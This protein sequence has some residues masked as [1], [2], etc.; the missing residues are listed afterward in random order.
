[1]KAEKGYYSLIQYCPD[2]GRAEVVNVG[3]VLFVPALRQLEVEMTRTA[4]R[5]QQVFGKGTIDSWWLRTVRDSFERGLLN[6]HG[7]G[8]FASSEDLDRYFGTLGNDII[9]TPSRP[10]RVENPR[11]SLDR[12]FARF[13]DATKS[14][15]DELA[16]P[17]VV[18]PLDNVFRRLYDRLVSIQFD[19]HF[20]IAEYPHQIQ[21]DY[22]YSNGETNLVRLLTIAERP[23]RAFDQAIKLGGESIVVKRHLR[24]DRREARLVVVA[25]PTSVTSTTDNTESKLAALYKDFPDAKWVPSSQI[26]DFAHCVETQAK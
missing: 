8:R 16:I 26:E 25:A 24:I 14:A 6:E 19:E 22:V 17:T 20:T 11:E 13:V 3:L 7:A 12:L 21:A 15:V 4:R 5:V 23:A 1:M 9:A 2:R 10:T 18:Q